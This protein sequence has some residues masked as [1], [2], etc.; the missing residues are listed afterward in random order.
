[1]VRAAYHAEP[2]KREH[3]LGAYHAPTATLFA[4]NAASAIGL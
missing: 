4:D 1:L 2:A 3:A